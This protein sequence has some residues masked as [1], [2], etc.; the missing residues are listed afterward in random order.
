MFSKDR[1]I[2]LFLT[3][4]ALI[5]RLI[6]INWGSPH[7]F[8]PDE[9]N[10]ATALSQL[11]WQSFNPNFFAYGQFPLYLGFFTLELFD[12]PNS[13]A[14]SIYI[15]RLYSAI[16]SLFSLVLIYWLSQKLFSQKFTYLVLLF[17]I[18][19]PG[20]IQLAHFGTTESFLI[21]IFLLEIYF[22]INIFNKKSNTL[23]YLL[24][25]IFSGVAI[26]TKLSSLIFMG[27]VFLVTLMNFLRQKNKIKILLNTFV[28][29]IITSIFYY[30]SSPYNII[31]KSDFLSTMSYETGVAT[32]RI[33]VFYTTQFTKT[34]PYIFQALKVFPYSAGIFQFVFSIIGLIILLKNYSVKDKKYLYYFLILIPSL[35]YFLYFG[36]LFTKWT[37]FVSPLFFLFPLLTAYFVS[38]LKFRPLRFI[39]IVLACL[40][41]LFFLR[42]YLVTDTRV[43]ATNYMLS[44]LPPQST[45]LS[46]SGNVVNLPLSENTFNIINYDFYSAYNPVTLAENLV[47]A[48]YILI[49]S[50]RIFKNYQYPYYQNLFNGSLGFKEI[51]KISPNYDLFLNSEE[52]EETWS[53]FDHPTIRIYEKVDQ[54][55]PIQYETLL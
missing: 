4:L 1:K 46:E 47:K 9:N 34:L 37:R 38:F 22:S 24:S 19:S 23:D 5:T 40:P 30:L 43:Q 7:F 15:L 21:F 28:L 6:G 29:I 10:M 39:S 36:Q 13:F 48:D 50:R 53:V 27:P 25:G 52:A 51:K 44:S 17:S 54:L 8:H 42:L 11:S 33:D 3:L 2:L 14:N 32:G 16:F 18:L 20:L 12:L 31:K 26:S 41:G 35:F 45:I 49:P 55:T